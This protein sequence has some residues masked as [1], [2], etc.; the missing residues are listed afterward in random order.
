M[1]KYVAF[2]TQV[3]Y[4]SGIISLAQLLN[5]EQIWMQN[6]EMATSD[7]W[8]KCTAAVLEWIPKC[9]LC[10]IFTQTVFSIKTT[11]TLNFK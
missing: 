7:E 4:R 8:N 1:S 11:N 3:C 5:G 9:I 6:Y 10:I 2:K